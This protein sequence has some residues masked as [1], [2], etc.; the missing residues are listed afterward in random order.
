MNGTDSLANGNGA[1]Q[2]AHPRLPNASRVS[3]AD[4]W[5]AM[6]SAVAGASKSINTLRPS[7]Y[8]MSKWRC[9]SLTTV[10]ID[11]PQ[12]SR[13]VRMKRGSSSCLCAERAATVWLFLLALMVT[14]K[15]LGTQT[16]RDG[17][18]VITSSVAPRAR[19]GAGS[20]G[21]GSSAGVRGSGMA[22]VAGADRSAR[23]NLPSPYLP[24]AADP[25]GSPRRDALP[26]HDHPRAASTGSI[27]RRALPSATGDWEKFH[28]PRW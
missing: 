1:A 9:T 15:T 24:R 14:D 23:A 25:L 27:R 19:S 16:W 5:L 18:I 21:W 17:Q 22:A 2:H 6:Y 10:R 4:W 13:S 28:R 11:T 26:L 20:A 12:P 3:R 7:L 8:G